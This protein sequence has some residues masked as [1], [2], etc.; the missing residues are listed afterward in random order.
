[1]SMVWPILHY[2]DAASA[3]DVL[4]D[5]FGFVADVVSADDDGDVVHAE[6]RAPG[7]GTVIVGS[8]KHG[9]GVHGDLGPGGAALYVVTEHVDAVA[10]RA[11]ADQR[12]RLIAA[13]HWTEFGNGGRAYAATVADHEGNRWTFGTYGRGR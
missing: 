5:V 9:D 11:E 8:T 4:V 1:M 10:R 3:V 13:P 2:D 6:L 7:G 12:A